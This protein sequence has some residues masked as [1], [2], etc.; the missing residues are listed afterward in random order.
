[1]LDAAFFT[2]KLNAGATGSSLSKSQ[3]WYV[4]P[5]INNVVGERAEYVTQEI[6]GIAF[7]VRQGNRMYDGTFYGN[8]AASPYIKALKS[9]LCQ[10]LGFFIIDVAG[11]VDRKSVVEGKR[12][13]VRGRRI[14][15]YE[16]R[17]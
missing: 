6:D 16:E 13:D 14:K 2:D 17:V 9:M 12:G 3:R 1:V 11:H 15:K 7:N 8:V 4:T 5:T 10:N